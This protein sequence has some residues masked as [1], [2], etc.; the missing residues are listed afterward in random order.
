ME[1]DVS[2]LVGVHGLQRLAYRLLVVEQL[3]LEVGEFRMAGVLVVER[4]VCGEAHG[5]V[6]RLIRVVEDRGLVRI[7]VGGGGFQLSVTVVGDVDV[8]GVDGLVVGDAFEL[9]RL[10]HD[11]VIV[12]AYRIVGELVE[13]YGSVRIVG[14][15]L[16]GLAI[17]VLQFECELVGVQQA[18]RVLRIVDYLAG[19]RRDGHRLAGIRVDELAVVNGLAILHGDGR[20]D[21]RG[22][23]LSTVIVGDGHSPYGV[24]VVIFDARRTRVAFTN[25]IGEGGLVFAVQLR[26]GEQERREFH[27]AVR[28]GV[29][30]LDRSACRLVV[31]IQVELEVGNL[32][33]RLV[34]VREQFARHDT[35]LR[36]LRSIRVRELDGVGLDSIIG[37]VG[38]DMTV[39]RVQIVGDGQ[40]PNT[41]IIRDSS[42]VSLAFLHL[43]LVDAFLGE[44]AGVD[45][46]CLRLV[47]GERDGGWHRALRSIVQRGDVRNILVF[48]S[49]SAVRTTV[50]HF[51]RFERD[52]NRGHDHAVNAM[53]FVRVFVDGGGHLIQCGE[54]L[55]RD[56]AR[57][58]I[59]VGIILFITVG[60]RRFGRFLRVL[61]GDVLS[62]P[63]GAGLRSEPKF[64]TGATRNGRQF[65]MSVLV[66]DCG[67]RLA[68][69]AGDGLAV[70]VQQG[71]VHASKETVC[72]LTHTVMVVVEPCDAVHSTFHD[73][74]DR[75]HLIITVSPTVHVSV[76]RLIAGR[77]ERETEIIAGVRGKL[78]GCK[79]P[80]DRLIA[81]VGDSH[82][83]SVTVNLRLSPLFDL[84]A[85]NL[86]RVNGTPLRVGG[87]VDAPIIQGRAI[88]HTHVQTGHHITA[89]ILRQGASTRIRHN[90][91]RIRILFLI[92]G[93]VIQHVRET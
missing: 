79:S 19:F 7:V 59:A 86:R 87:E 14:L 32:G 67:A 62:M 6:L 57:N 33:G 31:R 70:L 81:T 48:F 30:G 38:R 69:H 49:P 39:E 5:H 71:D 2:V 42:I 18:E 83:T 52:R 74:R 51:D 75:I 46:D 89:G 65:V 82:R 36:I 68:V 29:H 91:N 24:M 15:G 23:Q 60:I 1:A 76:S 85:R 13:G 34:R 11:T 43:I 3:E 88:L 4:L 77:F 10:F 84:L 45:S 64:E 21:E 72:A 27:F 20:I 17:L 22:F 80:S 53:V 37:H 40:Y 56:Y 9:S 25:R 90:I 8:H 28:R 41:V 26:L 78:V 58:H 16:D 54:I 55:Q 61:D 66:G 35:G 12:F 92:L 50:Q 63:S 93:E 47:V 73:L 44:R